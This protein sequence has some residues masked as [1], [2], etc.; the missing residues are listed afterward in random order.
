MNDSSF[1]CSDVVALGEREGAG[2]VRGERS[3]KMMDADQW[4]RGRDK[5][6]ESIDGVTGSCLD[7]G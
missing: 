6:E 7:T 5:Q 3:A 4:E 1:K 2:G